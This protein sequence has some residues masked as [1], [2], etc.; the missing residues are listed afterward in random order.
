MK[1]ALT[2]ITSISQYRVPISY[3]YF[4]Q[5]KSAKE[6]LLE[7]MFIEEK[8]NLILENYAELE[9]ELFNYSIRRMLFHDFDW[10]STVDKMHSINRK[11][12]NLLTTCRLYIDQ[13]SHNIHKIYSSDSEQAKIFKTQLSHE[14]DS[15]FGYR[16]MEAMRNYVQHRNLPINHINTNMR[17]I[18]IK[19][20]RFCKHT[21]KLNINVEDLSK[22]K[23]FKASVLSELQAQGS[24]VEFIPLMRQYLESIGTVHLKIRE[25]LRSDLA[26]GESEIYQA[27]TLC[28]E[29]TD[30][31]ILY[32]SASASPDDSNT[33]VEAVEIF[34]DLIKRRQMF[35]RKNNYPYYSLHYVSSEAPEMSE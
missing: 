1:Y 20:K 16:V 5:L 23:K 7:A 12:I 28:K 2:N 33:S 4:N 29:S 30:N 3:E 31:E 13:V 14:Y 18:E 24:L 25:L 32:I 11:I 35:E 19:D 9:L 17:W 10:S 26:R 8:F 34:E 21:V 6:F 22:D 27:I 15:V